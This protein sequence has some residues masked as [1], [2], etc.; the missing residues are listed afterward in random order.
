LRFIGAAELSRA[1]KKKPD[2]IGLFSQWRF[3]AS[4]SKNLVEFLFPIQSH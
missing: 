2:A 1:E 4:L 3:L